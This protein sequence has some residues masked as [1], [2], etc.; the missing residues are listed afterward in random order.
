M[1]VDEF[2][3][4]DEI[5][6]NVF[7]EISWRLGSAYFGFADDAGRG[8]DREKG[9]DVSASSKHDDEDEQPGMKHGD[10]GN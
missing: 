10:D 4:T 9:N 6:V 3:D 1:E 2:D 7:D 8:S 5:V